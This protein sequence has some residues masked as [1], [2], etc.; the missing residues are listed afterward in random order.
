MCG[1]LP[2]ATDVDD[3]TTHATDGERATFFFLLKDPH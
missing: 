3:V 1:W 2:P